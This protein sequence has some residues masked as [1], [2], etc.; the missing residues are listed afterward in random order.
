MLDK[1]DKLNGVGG[2][3]KETKKDLFQSLLNLSRNNKFTKIYIISNFNSMGR[4]FCCHA[5]R[6]LD[7]DY[8]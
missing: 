8:L 2:G 4:G 6:K 1:L 7:L 5:K 3:F